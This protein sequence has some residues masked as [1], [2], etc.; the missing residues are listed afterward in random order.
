[1]R[2]RGFPFHLHVLPSYQ[3]GSFVNLGTVFMINSKS[4]QL[5]VF[6]ELT[7]GLLEVNKSK[8]M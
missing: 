6:V 2:L 8:K 3:F 4:L 7:Y 1:M 5:N